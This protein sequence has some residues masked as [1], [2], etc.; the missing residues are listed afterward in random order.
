M[1]AR[2]MVGQIA[3]VSDLAAGHGGNRLELP[4]AQTRRRFDIPDL[5]LNFGNENI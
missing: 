2:P 5:D 3:Y 4:C 1:N